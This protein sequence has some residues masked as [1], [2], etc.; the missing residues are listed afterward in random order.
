MFLAAMNALLF[1]LLWTI[2]DGNNAGFTAFSAEETANSPTKK[3]VLTKG[4]KDYINFDWYMYIQIRADL[5]GTIVLCDMI[6]NKPKTCFIY[7]FIVWL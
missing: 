7:Y 1:L 2:A 6:K 3:V 5:D 4:K